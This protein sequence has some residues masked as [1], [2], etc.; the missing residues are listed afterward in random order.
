MFADLWPA[1]LGLALCGFIIAFTL[2]PIFVWVGLAGLILFG[3]G[4]IQ[5]IW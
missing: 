5:A 2:W 4:A 1:P 3:L